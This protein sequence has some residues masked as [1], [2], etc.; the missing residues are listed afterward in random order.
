MPHC[1]AQHFPYF[2]SRHPHVLALLLAHLPT[3]RLA[4]QGRGG[5]QRLRVPRHHQLRLRVV[6]IASGWSTNPW[7]QIW[8]ITWNSRC[9]FLLEDLQD[10]TWCHQGSIGEVKA[11]Y[12]PSKVK[13]KGLFPPTRTS[14]V[15]DQPLFGQFGHSRSNEIHLIFTNW[16]T[17]FKIG[18]VFRPT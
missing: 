18:S 11:H 5:G 12:P 2:F 7:K 13:V 6:L 16:L 8:T 1:P 9:P 15:Q 17:N 4:I 3:Q 10:P 14:E